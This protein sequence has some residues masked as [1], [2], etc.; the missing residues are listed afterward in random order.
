MLVALFN[1]GIDQR[2]QISRFILHIVDASGC[3]RGHNDIKLREPQNSTDISHIVPK[4]AGGLCLFEAK[5][6]KPAAEHVNGVVRVRK[7]FLNKDSHFVPLLS[8]HY[9]P[10]SVPQRVSLVDLFNRNRL[11]I[12][13]L[14]SLGELEVI[15]VS[16]VQIFNEKQRLLLKVCLFN[17]HLLLLL[18]LGE[19]AFQQGHLSVLSLIEL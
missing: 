4:F 16:V 14:V 9:F 11:N 12:G 7:D 3:S 1:Q 10:D 2:V 17:E 6:G 13:F 15:D 5:F 18:F 8:M 19:C